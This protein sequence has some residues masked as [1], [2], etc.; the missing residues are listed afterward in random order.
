MTISEE[1]TLNKTKNTLFEAISYLATAEG[2]LRARL[3]NVDAI[4][5]LESKD[6]PN[7][8]QGKWNDVIKLLTK[9]P[10]ENEDIG[11]TQS[12]L[13]RMQNRTASK[14]SIMMVKLYQEISNIKDQ[15]I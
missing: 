6:F 7:E 11:I 9:F 3:K 13:N 10:I 15:T 5:S 14:I 1:Y 8:L 2:D 12:N 4:Y